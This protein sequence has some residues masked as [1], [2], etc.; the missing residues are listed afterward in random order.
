MKNIRPFRTVIPF[1]GFGRKETL[2]SPVSYNYFHLLYYYMEDKR[3][4]GTI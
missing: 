4:N 2:S 1:K 3:F